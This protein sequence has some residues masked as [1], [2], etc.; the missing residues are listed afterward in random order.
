MAAA[1]YRDLR[2]IGGELALLQFWLRPLV[3]PGVPA[4]GNEKD[5]YHSYHG[6]PRPEPN[7][8]RSA[9]QNSL[10]LRDV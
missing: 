6:Q 4:K 2:G 7:S 1:R 5:G 9:F 8:V 10:T 3:A